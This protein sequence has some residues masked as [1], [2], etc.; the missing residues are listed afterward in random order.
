MSVF[1]QRLNV[2]VCPSGRSPSSVLSSPTCCTVAQGMT[3][4]SPPPVDSLLFAVGFLTT[5]FCLV[6]SQPRSSTAGWKV[7]T[8]LC[9]SSAPQPPHSCPSVCP[10]VPGQCVEKRAFYRLISGLHASINIHLSARYLLDGE[11]HPHTSSGSSTCWS[12]SQSVFLTLILPCWL[13]FFQTAGS[14]RSGVTTFPSSG[15]VS[16]RS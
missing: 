4:L 10:S 3:V 9:C 8:R 16:T 12:Y 15:G 11:T 2:C 14:R 6:P 1:C 13:L 7:S 5:S